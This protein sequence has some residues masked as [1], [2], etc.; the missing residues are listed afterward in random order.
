MNE[1]DANRD[2]EEER[3]KDGILKRDSNLCEMDVDVRLLVCMC[4][5][6]GCLLRIQNGCACV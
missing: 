4:V 6:H 2:D 3:K 5:W 1:S